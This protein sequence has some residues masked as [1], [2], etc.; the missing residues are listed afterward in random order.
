MTDNTPEVLPAVAANFGATF[1]F[2]DP[3]TSFSNWAALC[4]AIIFLIFWLDTTDIPY[5]E[6]LPSIPGLPIVGNLVQLGSEQ[7]R[8]LA[9]L[10]KKYGP[11]FQIRLGN[12]VG[13]C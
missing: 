1:P 4:G 3:L 10:S 8:R 11:V 12:K 13:P 2:K 6:H 9:Q 5:I 7:P